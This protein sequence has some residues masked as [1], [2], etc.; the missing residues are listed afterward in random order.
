MA[1]VTG[2]FYPNESGIGYGTEL[3]VGQGDGTPETFVSVPVL[4]KITPGD[5]TTGIVDATHLRSPK[6]HREKKGTLRDSG[7]IVCEGHYVPGHGA[8]NMAGGD[9]F[10]AAHSLIS[11]WQTVAQ[12]N[13]RIVMPEE[14]FHSLTLDVRGVISKY[15]VGEMSTENL[16]PFTLEITPLQDYFTGPPAPIAATGATAG[17]PGTFTPTGA[18]APANLAGLTGIAAT[19]STLWTTGQYVIL[20]DASHAHWSGTAWVAGDA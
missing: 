5:L 10:D 13:Y 12:N 2:E 17:S 3:G 8:H 1:D 11:L 4:M 18:T 7:A 19:P 9:G 16:V 14:A 20:G 6:R 15:Q